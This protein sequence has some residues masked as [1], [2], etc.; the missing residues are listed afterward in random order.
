MKKKT[1]EKVIEKKF[2]EWLATIDNPTVAKLVRENS[3]ITGGCIAS[4]LLKE[5]IKDYDVYFRNKETAMAVAEYYV[6]KFSKKI[7]LRKDKD[8]KSANITV[9]DNDGRI[10]IV[11]KSAG[12]ASE[13]S[14]DNIYKYFESQEPSEGKSYVNNIAKTLEETDDVSIEVKTDPKYQPVF[15]SAN[16][17]TLSDKIQVIIRFYGEHNDI[18]GN[19][20]F[21]HCTNYWDSKGGLVLNQPALEALLSKEL[22][23]IGSKY[24]LCSII[25]TRKFIKRGWNINAGQY[26]KM[27]Y[28][29]SKLD[30]DNFEVLEDQLTGVDVA[31]FH[32]LIDGLKQH[33]DKTKESGVEFK[34]DYGYLARI[35][36]KIF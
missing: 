12:I 33:A 25:R 36:D 11:I 7:K 22:Y 4:M 35:I 2:A 14:G 34:L 18:H 5:E 24:P 23:Y 16:A 29:L 26:L 1:I 19:Y 28:Q 27:C 13:E 3:I 21:I 31:Y 9:L 20:D 10:K 15:L 8:V 17:I 32:Q 6:S 30:L